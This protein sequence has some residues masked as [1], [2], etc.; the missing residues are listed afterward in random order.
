MI[1]SAL[2][3][4]GFNLVLNQK[5]NMESM[6]ESTTS[7]FSWVDFSDAYCK[8]SKL[9]II[10]KWCLKTTDSCSIYFSTPTIQITLKVL[11]WEKVF[12]LHLCREIFKL[13]LKVFSCREHKMRTGFGILGKFIMP[14]KV[15]QRQI[16]IYMLCHDSMQSIL[17][18]F[19]PLLL[20][21]VQRVKKI[22]VKWWWKC[23]WL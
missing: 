16:D 3:L 23:F 2:V 6:A 15:C 5:C 8:A 9:C 18:C 14:D 4:K 1:Y 11:N 20:A 21:H 7:V 12:C 17:I 19:H 13:F 22:I 10:T